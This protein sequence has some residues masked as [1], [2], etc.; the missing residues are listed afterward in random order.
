MSKRLT[1]APT[2]IVPYAAKLTV[3][4]RRLKDSYGLTLVYHHHMMMVAETFD[5]ISA[6]F[7]AAGPEVGLLLDTGHARAAGFDFVRL[8][9]RF[10]NRITHIHLKDVRAEVPGEG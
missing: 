9:E 7:D 6:I 10:A 4:S 2:E 5:E 8:I 3:F 1:L